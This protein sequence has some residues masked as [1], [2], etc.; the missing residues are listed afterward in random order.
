MHFCKWT[1]GVFNRKYF[2]MISQIDDYYISQD[3]PVKGCLLALR[4]IIKDKDDQI[5]ET[6]KYGMPCFCYRNKPFCYLW[7]DKKTGEPYILMVE[8]KMINHPSLESGTRS[9]MKVLKINPQEDLDMDL[10]NEIL[11]LG[12]DL[13]KDGI[14][15][16]K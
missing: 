15:K 1:V 5:S 8:G 14:V 11:K 9:R 6:T 12:L 13:Y 10:I 7:T 3:E 4:K 16:V 2:A